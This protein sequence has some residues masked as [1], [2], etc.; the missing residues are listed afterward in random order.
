VSDAPFR[1]D[2][3]SDVVCPYCCIGQAQ[4]DRALAEFSRPDL[5]VLAHRAFELH[6]RSP[7]SH[8]RG[9]DELVA[10]KYDVSIE[11]AAAGHRRL[12]AEAAT[13]GLAWRLEAAR[14]ANT[15]DAHRLVAHAGGQGRAGAMVAALFAAYFERGL[16]VSDHEVLAA[17]AEEA[18]VAGAE[19]LLAGDERTDEVRADEA[20]ALELGVGG[21]PAFL[22]D[23]R[24]M[25][26]GAQGEATI[27][28]TLERALARRGQLA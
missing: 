22:L 9:L 19:E 16:L 8:E 26:L 20:D 17:L 15:F 21:V 25:V 10:A 18:G 7:A 5:V 14:P 27:L 2:I 13:Y 23:G 3:W 6:P 1:I 12:A 28:A 24:F 4:L 11:Q